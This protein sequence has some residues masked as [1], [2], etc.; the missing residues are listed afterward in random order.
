MNVAFTVD[1]FSSRGG[2]SYSFARTLAEFLRTQG[3][4]IGFDLKKQHDLVL[5]FAHTGSFRWIAWQKLRGARIVHRLDERID[6]E[7][8]PARR[9]KHDQLIR[10][11]RYSD[12]TIFQS[13]FVEGN[14]GAHLED[15]RRVVIHNGVDAKL[16]TPAG[17][18]IPLEGRP[19]VLNTTWSVGDIKRLD[20]LQE[21]L[22]LPY[23]D[24]VLHLVGRH[25]K[26]TGAW[27]DH[28]RVRIHGEKTATEVAAFMRSADLFFF[29]SEF[30]PCPNT[31]LEAMASGCPILYHPSGG[32]PEL[33]G[34]AGIP[35]DTSVAVAMQQALATAQTLRARSLERAPRFQIEVVAQQYLEALRKALK[36]PPGK[37]PSLSTMAGDFWRNR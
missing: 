6:A 8:S 14:V 37:G 31:I 30:D 29:P 23:P 33:M 3:V 13:R 18:R 12:L 36:D 22:D 1:P 4:T 35:L 21:I 34:D 32:T 10:L 11:N 20:R 16:F 7:E 28:P 25:A 26:A 9:V 5:L 24:L 27:K 17:P 19:A 15:P 2:G